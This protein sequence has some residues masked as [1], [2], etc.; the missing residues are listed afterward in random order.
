MAKNKGYLDIRFTS[1]D[2]TTI[3]LSALWR[4]YKDGNL[5]TGREKGATFMLKR[6]CSETTPFRNRGEGLEPLVKH[7]TKIIKARWRAHSEIMKPKKANEA[8]DVLTEVLDEL[9]LSGRF[10]N[11]FNGTILTNLYKQTIPGEQPWRYSSQN[12]DS[13]ATTPSRTRVSESK[14]DIVKMI[15]GA[16]DD[17]LWQARM[18]G[19]LDLNKRPPEPIESI[20]IND[21]GDLEVVTGGEISE[22]GRVVYPVNEW[23]FNPDKIKAHAEWFLRLL[24]TEY[25]CNRPVQWTS[26]DDKPAEAAELLDTALGEVFDTTVMRYK[27]NIVKSSLYTSAVYQAAFSDASAQG[28]NVKTNEINDLVIDCLSGAPDRDRRI[29]DIYNTLNDWLE[30]NP[31]HAAEPKEAASL[32]IWLLYETKPNKDKKHKTLYTV[33][34]LNDKLWQ[35]HLTYCDTG[36]LFYTFPIKPIE[37]VDPSPE[38]LAEYSR[39]LTADEKSIWYRV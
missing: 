29:E 36:R 15:K 1:W 25:A 5:F 10:A 13:A 19:I 9:M 38:G 31:E 27:A 6:I 28:L 11:E 18:V 4:R 12:K 16:K 2:S 26:D 22:L 39:Q 17:T 24:R 3:K 35:I 32:L 23:Y 33:E 34:A 30:L 20:A 37:G 14:R 7:L 21:N 8:L